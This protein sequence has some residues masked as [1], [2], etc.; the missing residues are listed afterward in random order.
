MDQEGYPRERRL[1][2]FVLDTSVFIDGLCFSSV[3]L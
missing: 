1:Y 2:L 3:V